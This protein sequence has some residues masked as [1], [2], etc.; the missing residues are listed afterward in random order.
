VERGWKREG[1]REKFREESRGKTCRI[2]REKMVRKQEMR[3]E[4]CREDGGKEE[5]GRVEGRGRKGGRK[6]QEGWSIPFFSLYN[7]KKPSY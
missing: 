5:A 1:R 4:G 6:R 7:I 3:R 2:G